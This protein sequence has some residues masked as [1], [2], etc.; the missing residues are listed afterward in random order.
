MELENDGFFSP[1]GISIP[2][3][4]FQVKRCQTL[5]VSYKGLEGIH[6]LV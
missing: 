6:Q 1:I 5:E 4:D 3:A 2:G